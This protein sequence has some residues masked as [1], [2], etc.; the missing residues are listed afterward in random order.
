[1][2]SPYRT[3]ALIP[4]SRRLIAWGTGERLEMRVPMSLAQTIAAF[5]QLVQ[6]GFPSRSELKAGDHRP[7]QG[8][9]AAP[10]FDLSP[11]RPRTAMLDVRVKLEAR[12]S[13]TIVTADIKLRVWLHALLALAVMAV[14]VAIFAHGVDWAGVL[15]VLFRVGL[16]VALTV[17]TTVAAVRIGIGVV[18]GLLVEGLRN[19][20]GPPARQRPAPHE[21]MPPLFENS[22]PLVDRLDAWLRERT[23]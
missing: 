4:L 9:V 20:H 13:V 21:E 5:E 3:F 10:E 19:D 8:Q 6:T 12:E 1:M 7:F 23:N 11:L 14:V 17:A 2:A 18:R 15:Y 22:T 16:V